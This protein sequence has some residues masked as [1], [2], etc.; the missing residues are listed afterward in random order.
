D[1]W[2]TWCGPCL[3]EMPALVKLREAHEEQGLQIVGVTL[4]SAGGEEKIRTV[5]R[6]YG[7]TWPQVYDG[8]GWQTRPAVVNS[9]RAIP[10]TILLDRNGVARY[11]GLRGEKL[12]AKVRELL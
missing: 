11:R 12:D 2:A 9:V 5:M 10:E 1:F 4:D 8:G 6:R 3:A 7:M